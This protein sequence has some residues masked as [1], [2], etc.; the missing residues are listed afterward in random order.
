MRTVYV[1]VIRTIVIAATFDARADSRRAGA[2]GRW[3]NTAWPDVI[4]STHELKELLGVPGDLQQALLMSE[5]D[6]GCLLHAATH[7]RRFRPMRVPAIDGSQLSPMECTVLP[8]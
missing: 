6:K 1:P 8:R 7:G 4:Y 3:Q 2:R 5:L